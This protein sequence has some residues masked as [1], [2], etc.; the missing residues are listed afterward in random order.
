MKGKLQRE[1]GRKERERERDSDIEGLRRSERQ[2]MLFARKR[3]RTPLYLRV[4]VF[5]K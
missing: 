5:I 1:R 4:L 2:L 3:R